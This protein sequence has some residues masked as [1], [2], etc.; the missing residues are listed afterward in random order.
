MLSETNCITE[1]S[2]LYKLPDLVI[3]SYIDATSESE[4]DSETELESDDEDDAPKRK[5]KGKAAPAKK[6]A[7]P[8]A[9]KAAATK[10]TKATKGAASK[11][12]KAT[13]ARGAAGKKAAAAASSTS[14]V[15]DLGLGAKRKSPAGMTSSSMTTSSAA[16]A[17]AGGKKVKRE[18]T[19]QEAEDEILRYMTE[20]N[21]PYAALQVYDNLHEAIK[22][23]LVIKI[24][25]KLTDE[26]KLVAKLYGK[27]K[28]YHVNQD[29]LPSADP[30]AIAALDE[31]LEA[32]A[33]RLSK[34]KEQYQIL[35]NEVSLLESGP[36]TAEALEQ[37][38]RL[39]KQIEEKTARLAKIEKSAGELNAK[40][41]DRV[42]Q[43][44]A[45][46]LK[47]WRKRQ[48]ACMEMVNLALENSSANKTPK[49]WM[50]EHG[51]E[52]DEDYKVDIKAYLQ[53]AEEMNVSLKK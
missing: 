34:A 19:G 51:L 2:C 1:P 48:R 20:Q 38:A 15:D 32:A 27:A 7:A 43:R 9:T 12:P 5:G 52:M 30:A 47:E 21:R 39:K 3:P 14:A 26:G 41:I 16:A 25:D 4:S 40:D 24:M 37:V 42:K 11:E 29:N 33:Q 46:V 53:L 45:D 6:A 8:K 13:T 49:A 44:F 31:A 17:G 18:L 23:P 10:A 35:T 50:R 28:I 36:T 22:K